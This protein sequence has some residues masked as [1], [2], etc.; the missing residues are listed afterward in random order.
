M[1]IKRVSIAVIVLSLILLIGTSVLFVGCSLFDEYI[2]SEQEAIENGEEEESDEYDSGRLRERDY[3]VAF[4]E[5]G[6]DEDSMHFEHR[7]A[8]IYAVSPDGSGR[9]LIF[10]DL[11]EKYDLGWIYG[12]SP[13]GS[14]MSCGFFE[15][16]RGAYSSLRVIGINTGETVT[17]AE[18]DYTETESK[19]L[20]IDIYGEPIWSNDSK[21]I[22]FETALN[23]YSDNKSDGGISIID[24]ET[25][26]I[27]DIELKTEETLI[28]SNTFI[29]PVLFSADGSRLFCI[30]YNRYPKTE[31]GEVL[32]YFSK[33]EKFLAIDISSGETSTI[34]DIGQFEGGEMSLSDFNLFTQQEKLVFQVLGD[35]EEDGDIWTCSTDGSD[36]SRLT[37]DTSLREQQPSILDM[38]GSVGE[39]VYVGVGRYG[40]I[41]GNFNSGDIFTIS[42][43]GS[44][45][46]QITDYGIGAAAPV[47]SP[48]GRYIAFMHYEYDSNME[49]VT[50]YNI[51]VYNMETGKIKT[52]VSSSSIL[53]LIGWVPVDE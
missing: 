37:S 41:A 29:T 31:D 47:Y 20:E 7:V 1:N 42:I 49:Y 12:I 39:L 50:G 26:N 4:L 14:M 51:E 9:R 2:G 17:A 36:L 35:F 30:L 43:D 13:D 23:P 48:C 40:T 15:D 44:G 38:P 33:S 3:L 52:A 27:R 32:G 46:N 24:I 8:G 34:L 53:D 10:T 11:N 25:G 16:G 19:E 21:R 5:I 45:K 22:A 18:F 28:G 6:I